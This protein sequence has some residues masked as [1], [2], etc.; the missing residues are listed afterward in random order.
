MSRRILEGTR[1]LNSYVIAPDE[2]QAGD[3]FGYKIIAVVSQWDKSWYAVRGSTSD[4]DEHVAAYG[5]KIPEK[6]AEA[7]FPS[8]AYGRIY[9]D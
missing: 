1:L 3:Q 2:V 7:L 4:S 6:A 9:N 8:V 5:D